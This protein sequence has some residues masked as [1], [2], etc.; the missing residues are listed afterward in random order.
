[1]TAADQRRAD[2]LVDV[3]ARALAD[4]SLPEQH[5]QR[6]AI[7]VTVQLS[8][9]PG[10]DNQPAHLDRYGPITAEMARRIAADQTG[11]RRRLVTDDTS[12]LLDYRRTTY[13]APTNLTNHVTAR[14]RTC[15]FP[16]CRRTAKLCDLDH[17]KPGPT[18]VRRT[19]TTLRPYAPD[20]TTPSTTP[21]GKSNTDKTAPEPG[22]VQ[23]DTATGY[24]YPTASTP[25]REPLRDEFVI[26]WEGLVGLEVSRARHQRRGAARR[27]CA[28]PALGASAARPS[29]AA[30]ENVIVRA[31]AER[32]LRSSRSS[33]SEN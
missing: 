10:C 7:S 8:T 11:T 21:A 6:P 32:F 13:R 15:T 20:T 28:V 9:L 25:L 29:R 17:S 26:F 18:A 16:G 5:G 33:S 4:P 24:H 23:R 12:Q 3:F 2:A 19:V 27:P 14:D 22:P 31:T 1:M 30:A